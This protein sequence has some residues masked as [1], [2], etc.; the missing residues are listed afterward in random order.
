[1]RPLVADVL[2]QGQGSRQRWRTES[3]HIDQFCRNR[4]GIGARQ[5]HTAKLHDNTGG[6]RIGF[7]AHRKRR[8][9]IVGDHYG[10]ALPEP[11]KVNNDIGALTRR[12]HE[13]L[14]LNRRRHETT[15]RAD[16][17]KRPAVGKTQTEKARVRPVEQAQAV[18]ARLDVHI[19][20]G[21]AID[22]NGIA[23]RLGVPERMHRRIVAALRITQ[24]A[25]DVETAVLDDD[26][27]LVV[28]RGQIE[29]ALQF[30]FTQQVKTG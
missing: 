29:C 22:D 18:F 3:R 13:R 8:H 28:A 30:R 27:T 17:H 9:S 16:L 21:L 4:T 26:F 20:P 10:L 7:I 25:L 23:E 11:G 24:L 15:V 6:T 19:G 5:R 14:H 12:K 2:V 1:M